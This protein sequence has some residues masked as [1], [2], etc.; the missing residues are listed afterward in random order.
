MKNKKFRQDRKSWFRT[1]KQLVRLR[2]RKPSFN[3]IGEKPTNGAIILSNH[4][5][6]AVPLTLE[7]YADYPIRMWGAHEMNS[8]LVKLYKY[9]TE[10]YYHQKRHW[11]IHLARLVCLIVSP[12]T[13]LYYKGL[14]LISTYTDT[15]FIK[16]TIKESVSVMKENGDNVVIYPEDSSQGY[17]PELT[18]FYSGF[19]VLAQELYNQGTDVNIFVAYYKKDENS[20]TFD[21]PVL[22][23]ELKK[24]F[25]NRREMAKHLLERCNNLGKTPNPV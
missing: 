6:A 20:Y 9:Q 17:F 8:G 16:K 12:L 7:L 10:I 3:Y 1:F 14:R 25:K 5:G 24:R 22:F 15:R 11:N 19:T 23:S 4:E 21:K 18:K 13:N 2:Y